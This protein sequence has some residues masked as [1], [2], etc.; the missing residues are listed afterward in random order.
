LKSRRV[1]S[2]T[3]LVRPKKAKGESAVSGKLSTTFGIQSN[4]RGFQSAAC[5]F[6]LA[7][8]KSPRTARDFPSAVPRRLFAGAGGVRPILSLPSGQAPEPTDA[9]P[10]S[11]RARAGDSAQYL[12]QMPLLQSQ[13]PMFFVSTVNA[14]RTHISSPNDMGEPV[15]FK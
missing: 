9:S 11:T 10:G 6:G 14:L 12:P 13:A 5:L 2:A 15:V 8:C 1:G 3:A 4:Q 7:A